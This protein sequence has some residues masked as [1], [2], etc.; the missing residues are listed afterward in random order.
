MQNCKCFSFWQAR[1]F[2]NYKCFSFLKHRC[3]TRG[4]SY[5]HI[6]DSVELF[7]LIFSKTTL[8]NVM[9]HTMFL[10]YICAFMNINEFDVPHDV[11]H[12]YMCFPLLFV[13][14]VP[15][16]VPHIYTMNTYGV[17]EPSQLR[18]I[19]SPLG[20]GPG[21]PKNHPGTTGPCQEPPKSH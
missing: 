10:I 3:S 9:F 6:C 17:P 19:P 7:F 5:I 12:I 11:P 1:R 21:P 4:S 20:P 16:D 18:E 2:Q 8:M 13:L 14:H 15:R